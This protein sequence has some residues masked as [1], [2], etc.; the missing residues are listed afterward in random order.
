MDLPPFDRSQMDG[1]AVRSEDVKKA[2]V[3]LKII[4]ESVAGKG[5]DRAMKSGEAVRIMTGARVPGG[6]D[7]VQKVEVTRETDGFVEILE[8]PKAG[9]NIN[10]RASE[11]KKGAKVF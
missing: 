10:N 8:A 5:F 4:G 11:I 6:A 1:F 2:P 9:Q 3:K 7:A